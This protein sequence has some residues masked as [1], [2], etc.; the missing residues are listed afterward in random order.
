MKFLLW[1]L[2]FALITLLASPFLTYWVM[3]LIWAILG[4][5]LGGDGVKAFFSAAMG[6]GI[7]WLGKSFWVT[8]STASPLPEMMG[9]IMGIN[10]QGALMLITALMGALIGG[11]SALTGNR[12]RKLFEKKQPYYYGR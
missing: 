5:I 4:I 2:L 11:F 9:E 10:H 1:M 7:V 3:M 12:F 8:W 6:V